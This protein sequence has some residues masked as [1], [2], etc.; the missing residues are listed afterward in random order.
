MRKLFQLV[1]EITVGGID[2]LNK[3]FGQIDKEARKV[4]R[5]IQTL[6]KNMEKTGVALTKSITAPI[7]GLGAA[8]VLAANKTGQYA[9]RLLDLTQ[10]TGLSTDSLQELEHVARVAGVDF[11]SLTGTITQFTRKLP[12]IVKENGHAYNSIKQLGINIYDANGNIR[13]MNKLFPEMLK[14]LMGVQNVTER[15]AI[16]TTI[17]GR[18]L[19][20]LAP[21]L[22]MTAEQ[23]DAVTKEAHDLNLIIDEE[24][25]KSADEYRKE[26]EKLKAEFT[27]FWQRLSIDF[28]PILRDTLIPLI[29]EKLIPFF[30]KTIKTVKG[31]ADWFGKLPEPVKETTILVVAM[32]AAAGPLL[33]VLGKIIIATK[34]YTTA[35]LTMNAALLANPFVLAGVA[36]AAFVLVLK[37][38]K[39]AYD[40]NIKAHQKWTALTVEEA[41][42]NEF[43]ESTKKLTES[44]I[45][46]GDALKDVNKFTEI[47]GKDIGKLTEDARKLGYV[48]EGDTTQKFKQLNNVMMF[49]NNTF[50]KNGKLV[51]ATREQLEKANAALVKSTTVITKATEGEAKATGD[52]IGLQK[53]LIQQRIEETKNIEKQ[54]QLR[55]QLLDI[56]EKEALAKTEGGE[57]ARQMVREIYAS[58]RLLVSRDTI[59]EINKIENRLLAEDKRREDERGKLLEDKKNKAKLFFDT[60]AAE[61]EKHK[62]LIVDIYTN[63]S[64]A[65]MTAHNYMSQI[66]DNYYQKKHDLMEVDKQK[67]I[68]RVNNSVLNEESKR[69]QIA[70]I[71]QKYQKESNKLKKEQAKRDK[72]FAMF[73]A[74]IGTAAAIVNALQLAWPL[75]LV[76]AILYGALGAFQIGAIASEPIPM[77]TG[78][79][80]KGNRGGVQAE[81]GEGDQDEIV[82]P[83]KTGV[84]ALA[85]ALINKLSQI[86]IPTLRAPQL[87]FAGGG[88][89]GSFSGGGGGSVNLHIGTL[90]ADEFG[91]KELERRLLNVR[92]AEQQRKG[93]EYYG[94]R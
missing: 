84:Q 74:I 53:Q 50:D 31:V 54:E 62:Q 34:A 91:L 35:I 14:K 85:D 51:F 55:L 30:E 57:A 81:I 86:E 3:Q 75:N 27:K 2:T 36:V 83:M 58:K 59:E 47:Y 73:N 37:G 12:E 32:A 11:N 8:M 87:A 78:A 17:F 61:E 43:I 7:M 1:G 23:F 13:D 89:G 22:G 20:D 71:E 60:W 28:I 26:M 16:A 52:L 9:D 65:V 42:Q 38:I 29:R 93:Q 67:E 92:V 63:I 46:H 40:D 68:D 80:V 25:L 15:N 64:Y 10:I 24:G 18:S 41:K 48:I 90:I 79:Y 44:M 6:G 45:Q 76:M 88:G 72:A 94:Y 39:D 4:Q 49:L 69:A 33:L 56:E 82:L 5:T 77:K 21:V 66:A 70:T 19:D